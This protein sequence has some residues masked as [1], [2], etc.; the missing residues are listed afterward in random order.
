MKAAWRIAA[1]SVLVVGLGSVAQ[2]LVAASR[3]FAY[4][5]H[6]PS[7]TLWKDIK[8]FFCGYGTFCD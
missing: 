6:C 4:S 5:E 8:S 3:A 7:C 2:P 1:I